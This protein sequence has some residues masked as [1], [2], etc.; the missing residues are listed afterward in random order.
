MT[1]LDTILPQGTTLTVVVCGFV[2]LMYLF[3]RYN[4]QI[5]RLL[6][7]AVL[8]TRKAIYSIF[9]VRLK[10]VNKRMMR[11]A[12]LNKDSMSYKVY[13]FFENIIITMELHADG[14]TVAGLLFFLLSISVV[15]AIVLGTLLNMSLFLKIMLCAAV[16]VVLIIGFKYVSITKMEKREAMVMDAVDLLVSDI[17][18]GVYNAVLRYRDNFN[19]VIR[20]YF[21]A[22][23]DDI[24]NK[25]YGFKQAMLQLNDQ[26]GRVFSDFAHKA[27]MYEEKADDTLED[28]FSSVIE[29]NRETRTLRYNNNR[30][31]NQ[32]Q[33][34]FGISTAII[35]VYAL[36][37]IATDAFTRDFLLNN[38]F[39]KLLIILDVLVIAGVLAYI[40]S[41][42][43][44]DL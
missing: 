7:K 35:I 26:L 31:F 30:M 2:Y 32:M 15:S 28:I 17:H 16:F 23:I 36:Y 27:I 24:Q 37:Q 29:V 42:R 5:L 21:E 33:T 10:Q 19:P 14:V 44:R 1:F 39:G 18:D 12:Y 13:A 8:S 22:F 6:T 20:P 40:T 4:A 11:S 3:I 41:L 9:G 43:S 25:G 34:Q 38:D